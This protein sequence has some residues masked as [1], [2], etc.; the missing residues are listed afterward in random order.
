MD[1]ER[2]IL[3]LLESIL[4]DFRAI[5]ELSGKLGFDILRVLC[6]H[7][8]SL[9]M[10]IINKH[11][12]QLL[13]L[14][15]SHLN[16]SSA[17]RRDLSNQENH[18]SKKSWRYEMVSMRRQ[19]SNVISHEKQNDLIPALLLILNSLFNQSYP[20]SSGNSLCVLNVKQINP[21]GSQTANKEPLW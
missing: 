8:R 9:L 4:G 19:P 12:D 15:V 13:K 6:C 20:L 1:R 18:G 2:Y 11:V 14:G 5:L 21:Q 3:T 17:E 10:S 16:Q 7:I